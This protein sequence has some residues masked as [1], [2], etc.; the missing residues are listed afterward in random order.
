LEKQSGK[1]PA[2]LKRNDLEENVKQTVAMAKDKNI[3]ILV[4]GDPLIATTH[5]IILNEAKKQ[6]IKCEV[7]HAPS[8]F[9]IAIGES[10]LD[11]YKFGPTV[12]IPFWSE[13]Y[14]PTSFI[15]AIQRNMQN[16]QHT[17]ILLDIDHKNSMPMR[18]SEALE[19]I[20][21]AQATK[22]TEILGAEA[23]IIIMANLGREDKT[24][25]YLKIAEVGADISKELEGKQIS[26]IVPGSLSFAEEENLRRATS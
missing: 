13:R 19:I 20:K 7:I 21:E 11:V 8:I 17:I 4:P 2:L 6:G 22:G 3:V 10:G 24:I 23:R 16:G 26:L 12:T 9:S 25:K 14:R 18:I 15:D 1:R 5:A